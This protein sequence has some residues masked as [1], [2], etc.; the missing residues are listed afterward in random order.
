MTATLGELT[1]RVRVVM[2]DSDGRFITDDVI[3]NW[4]NEAQQDLAARIALLDYEVSSTTSGSTIALP[5]GTSAPLLEAIQL[6]VGTGDGSE[7]EF[8][9]I[10]NFQMWQDSTSQ[11][12]NTLGIVFN[13]NIELYPAPTTGTAYRLRY[14]GMPPI[15]EGSDD[16][17][18]LPVQLERKLV[19]YAQ[20]QAKY[21]DGEEGEGDRYLQMYEQGLPPVSIGRESFQPGPM[22]LVPEP[23]WFDLDR[24]G[25]G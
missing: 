14:K 20:S 19:Q 21:M 7:V 9:N 5:S 12:G 25:L 24:M 17:H 11:P 1:D 23:T 4:L 16:L 22:Q 6:Q 10:D 18:S 3:A 13:G 8:T 2:R 15:M